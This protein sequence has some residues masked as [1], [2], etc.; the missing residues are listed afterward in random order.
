MDYLVLEVHGANNIGS[1]YNYPAFPGNGITCIFTNLGPDS[2]YKLSPN[3]TQITRN[4]PK[5]I[6]HGD[7]NGF[8]SDFNNDGWLDLVVGDAAYDESQYGYPDNQRMFFELQD[9]TTHHFRDITH[10]LGFITGTNV[11]SIVSSSILHKIRRPSVMLPVDYDLDGADD[12]FK[13]PYNTPGDSVLVLHNNVGTRNNHI[14]IKLI[15]PSGVNKSCIGAR[16]RVVSGNLKQMKDVYG[17]QGSQ[18]NEY[19]FIQNFGLG[20]RTHIDTIDVRWPNNDCTHTII[21][22]VGVNQFLRIDSAGIAGIMPVGPNAPNNFTLYPNPD[23]GSN[24]NVKFQ[25]P[26]NPFIEIYN[27]LGQ[28]V[29]DYKPGYASSFSL[30]VNNLP[31]GLYFVHIIGGPNGTVLTKSFVKSNPQ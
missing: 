17:C 31:A 3:V 1:Q 6:T 30:P 2:N 28:Q 19:P 16:I 11:D 7:H 13:C 9:T 20:K 15:A 12:I 18:T 8:W 24:L 27:E 14:T 21:T 29:A 10:E 26:I 5:N 25:G 23:A 4:N 22:N